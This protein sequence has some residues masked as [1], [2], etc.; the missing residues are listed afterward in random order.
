[1]R[2]VVFTM[3]FYRAYGAQPFCLLIYYTVGL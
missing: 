1:M 2:K 3:P